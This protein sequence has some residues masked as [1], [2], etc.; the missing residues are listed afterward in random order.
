[1]KKYHLIFNENCNK[2]KFKLLILSG[3]SLFIGLTE[4]LPKKFTLIG[5]DLSNNQGVLGWFIFFT[6]LVVLIYFVFSAILGLID[7]YL[8]ELIKIKTDK[9]TGETLGLTPEE[10]LRSQG[11]HS[12]TIENIGTP[13]QELDDINRQNQEIEYS[14]NNFYISAHNF[15]VIC[16]EFFIPI[17]FSIISMHYLYGFLVCIK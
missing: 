13:A 7:Y 10:C 17:I 16:F 5:L 14:Y 12:E 1:M 11:D 3:T 4:V 15:L 2:L 6:T 9:T 8:P